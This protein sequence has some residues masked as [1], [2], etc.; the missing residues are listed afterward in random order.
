MRHVRRLTLA[1]FHHQQFR[2]R[3]DCKNGRPA[4]I[5][6]GRVRLLTDFKRKLAGNS[7]AYCPTIIQFYT[8]KSP[9][10]WEAEVLSED[11]VR[12]ILTE[13]S[14]EQE[15]KH[16]PVTDIKLLINLKIFVRPETVNG[17]IGR[18]QRGSYRHRERTIR[19][20]FDR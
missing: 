6:N 2:H 5:S 11:T 8:L 10:I 1:F 13:V 3:Y 9:L 4:H 18:C 15:G 14:V 12:S 20:R 16:V 7:A 19:P 17:F